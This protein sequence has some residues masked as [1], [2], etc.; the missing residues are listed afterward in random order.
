MNYKNLLKIVMACL[1][2]SGCAKNNNFIDDHVPEDTQKNDIQLDRIAVTYAD[3]NELL[4]T[5]PEFLERFAYSI[6]NDYEKVRT[7]SASDGWATY[8]TIQMNENVIDV[9]SFNDIKINDVHYA[10]TGNKE[11]VLIEIIYAN[12]LNSKEDN[13]EFLKTTQVNTIEEWLQNIGREIEPNVIRIT[14]GVTGSMFGSLKPKYDFNDNLYIYQFYNV[15][16]MKMDQFE[17]NWIEKKAVHDSCKYDKTNH[18]FTQC[19][20]YEQ[21]WILK[22]MDA[23]LV[24]V[25]DQ[26]MNEE[27]FLAQ[28][29]D[30][31]FTPKR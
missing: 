14:D 16:K 7:S 3:G 12:A 2:L 20:E 5:H 21:T 4:I 1:L 13:P 17:Y 30:F 25:E 15:E 31:V 9:M 26:F 28:E 27:D 11:N 18:T 29:P 19:S 22:G 10:N 24:N 8:C 23:F 6:E